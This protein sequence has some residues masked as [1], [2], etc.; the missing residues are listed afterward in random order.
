MDV[1]SPTCLQMAKITH[2]VDSL[3]L[4]Q[5][6]PD[7]HITCICVCV[8]SVQTRDFVN[9]A[10]RSREFG[11]RVPVG[12]AL[13]PGNF[14]TAANA[15]EFSYHA[16]TQDVRSALQTIGLEDEGPA[17]RDKTGENGDCTAAH[18]MGCSEGLSPFSR[19]QGEPNSESAQLPLVVFFGAGLLGGP[20]WRV[21]VALGMVSSV[22][23][24]HARRTGQRD[25][26]LNLVV[27]RP[28]ERGCVCIGYQ[29]DAFGIVG[30]V[31]DVRRIGA[32][33]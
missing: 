9:V 31:R 23:A 16:A 33:G 2:L 17:A 25:V 22:F 29:G 8:M 14:S 24:S 27:E 26:R 32:D 7:W 13:L 15:G 3:S 1:T 12:I 5:S 6:A 28:G 11:C 30:L 4:T 21:A 18:S 10:A 20:P 19:P